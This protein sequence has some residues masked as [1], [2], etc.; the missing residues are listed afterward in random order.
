MKYIIEGGRKLEGEVEVSGS[1]NASLPILAASILSGKTTK[2]YN[3]PNIH[4]TQIT[5]KILEIL[6]CEVTK[7][8]NKVI[9]DSG[10]MKAKGI[11][12]DLMIQ[13]RSSVVLAGAIIGRFKEATFPYPGGCEIG[14]RPIDLHLKGLRKLG[15]NIEE[16]LGY[17]KCKCEEIIGGNVHLDFPSVGATENIMMASVFATRCNNYKQCS[18]GARNSRF[19]KSFKQNG[20]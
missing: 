11:P 3:V 19:R 13:M 1:K 7:K 16:E 15:I 6:G 4:D 10:K 5:R 9:I 14:A 20:S 17:I 12:E 2:L 8:G 18:Y